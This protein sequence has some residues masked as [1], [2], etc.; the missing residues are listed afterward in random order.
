M[1]KRIKT[2]LRLRRQNDLVK[3]ICILGLAGIGF[4]IS[5]MYHVWTIYQFVGTPAEYVLTGEGLVSGK[6]LDE[7]KQMN[8][9]MQVSRQL[10]VSA[11]LTYRGS[12]GDVEC[13]M[14][15]QDYLENMFGTEIPAGTKRFYMNEAA[16]AQWKQTL[17]ENNEGMGEVVGERQA[18]GT[19]ELDVRYAMSDFSADDMSSD[20]GDTN[21]DLA[22]VYKTAKLVVVKDGREEGLTCTVGADSQL[23][24]EAFGLR[25]KFAGHDLDGL[26][27][28]KLR[29]INYVIENED[30]VITEEYEIKMR[31]C[32]V[33]YGLLCSV[34]CAVGVFALWHAVRKV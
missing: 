21:S 3:I 1:K 10:D 31:L 11:T 4:F 16:F 25:V 23:L 17:A 30:V 9:I 8:G 12:R 26:Q 33:W 7:L 32:H 6:R 28:S 18:D 34:I 5:A 15:S 14:V 13:L 2:F 24:K 19:L 22:E 29:K 27:V 20:D